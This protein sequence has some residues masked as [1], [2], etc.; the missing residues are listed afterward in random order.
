MSDPLVD[1]GIPVYQ[2]ATYVGQ[3]IE[4]VQSQSYTNWRLTVSEELGPT[5]A[6]RRVVE[7]YL[8]D[9]RI[10]YVSSE[11]RF[12]LGRHKT[13]LAARGAGVYTTILDD[14]DCWYA[15]WLDR[16]VEFLES[17]PECGLVWGGHLDIDGEGKE[18][19]RVPLPV[20]GGVHASEAFITTMLR[21]NIVATP[22]VLLRREAYVRAGNRYDERFPQICDFEL[23]LRM[24]LDGPVGFVPVHDAAYRLHG[25]QMSRRHDRG[26]EFFYLV[27][28][29][30]GLFAA[31]LPAVRLPTAARHRLKAERLLSAALDAAEVGDRRAAMRRILRA[32]GLSP[33]AL[34]SGRALGAIAGTLGGEALSRRIGSMRS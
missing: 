29:L 1:I 8:A 13:R 21:G 22:D 10:E 9:E 31:Q 18:I 11:V 28:H 20:E 26:M 3:A 2:R 30:D 33:Q 12:G 32:A 25:Q 4:S 15:G 14:D 6:I 24:A 23:W 7:P 27:D 34:A 17:H 16:R 19:R 5:D